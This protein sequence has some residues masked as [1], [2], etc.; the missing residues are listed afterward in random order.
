VGELVDLTWLGE[1]YAGEPGWGWAR[2]PETTCP[3]MLVTSLGA[4]G[5]NSLDSNICLLVNSDQLELGPR[6]AVRRRERSRIVQRKSSRGAGIQF[7]RDF[8]KQT[9]FPFRQAF[10]AFLRNEANFLG[11][12]RQ[13]RFLRNEAN[14]GELNDILQFPL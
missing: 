3:S 1:P 10:V 8:A 11:P 6:N 13:P 2:V 14:F 12:D 7:A 4:Q 5:Q 9:Q